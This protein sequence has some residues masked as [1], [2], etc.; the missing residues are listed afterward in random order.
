M[1]SEQ[2]HKNRPRKALSIAGL[3]PCGGAGI[4]ADVRAFEN[5]GVYGMG[6]ATTLTFQ[7]TKGMEGRFDPGGEAVRRQ[8]EVLL[9]DCRPDAVKVGALGNA[10]SDDGFFKVLR[11]RYDGPVVVDPVLKSAAGGDLDGSG[12]ADFLL[13]SLVPYASIVT[14]NIDEVSEVWGFSVSTPGEMEEAS[15]GIVETG[16]NAVL[17]TGFRHEGE[18]EISALDIYY[19]GENVIRFKAAWRDGL[20]VHGTGCVLSSSIAAYLALGKELRVAVRLGLETVRSAIGNAVR[21]G[22][23]SKC[24][25]T[26]VF[27]D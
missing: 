21:I 1:V 2:D 22:K 20:S 19:D 10:F 27:P 16:A 17:I 11:D 12:C 24:A 25:N 7:N 4:L 9:D 8:L 3:D 13:G 6:I 14:P 26:A 5:I 15:L 18:D 23:G